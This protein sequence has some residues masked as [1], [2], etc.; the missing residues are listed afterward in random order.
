MTKARTS[1]MIALL[2]QAAAEQPE[3]S[4]DQVERFRRAHPVGGGR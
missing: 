2:L 1:G 3:L 4:S